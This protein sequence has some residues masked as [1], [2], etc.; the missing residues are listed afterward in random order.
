[1]NGKQIAEILHA[2][3]Q[4]AELSE[5]QALTLKLAFSI[6]WAERLKEDIDLAM[7]EDELRNET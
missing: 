1:M 5:G 6:R 7:H 2:A 4:D 3:C